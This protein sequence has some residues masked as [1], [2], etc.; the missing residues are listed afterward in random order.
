MLGFGWGLC[1]LFVSKITQKVGGRM[2]YR[3]GRTHYPDQDRGGIPILHSASPSS[4][5]NDIRDLKDLQNIPF[6][7]QSLS[8]LENIFS[9]VTPTPGKPVIFLL[10]YLSADVWLG[11]CFF[12]HHYK[13]ISNWKTWA[14]V[15]TGKLLPEFIAWMQMLRYRLRKTKSLGF[16]LLVH[17]F[18]CTFIILSGSALQ[19]CGLFICAQTTTN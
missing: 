1:S 13:N 18:K 3:S 4:N 12:T 6:N 2:Q 14:N 10:S 16:L 11:V 8:Q 17:I 5:P 19:S 7:Y 15:W 9:V